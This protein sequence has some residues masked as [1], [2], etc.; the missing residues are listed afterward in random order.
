MCHGTFRYP[1]CSSRNYV[2]VFIEHTHS[3][4]IQFYCILTKNKI[5]NSM[6]KCV[7][8]DF[9]EKKLMSSLNYGSIKN[10]YSSSRIVAAFIICYNLLKAHFCRGEKLFFPPLPSQKSL[11][12]S[13]QEI[14]ACLVI[15]ITLVYAVTKECWHVKFK[16][17]YL[18]QKLSSCSSVS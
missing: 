15:Y 17:S 6:S 5:N 1:G 10:F 8:Q 2:F 14:R 7:Y 16:N 13:I 4:K 9:Y 12:C 11:F 18:I 3:H